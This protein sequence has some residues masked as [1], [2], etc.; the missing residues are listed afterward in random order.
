MAKKEKTKP[1]RGEPGGLPTIEQLEKE[2]EIT[3]LNCL[4]ALGKVIIMSV[5]AYQVLQL[6]GKHVVKEYRERLFVDESIRRNIL[7]AN[8]SMVETS[9]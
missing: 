4:M 7:P 9:H 8:E 3:S 5:I 1:Q 2:M 6:T